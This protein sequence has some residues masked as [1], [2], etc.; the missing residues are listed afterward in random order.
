M[1]RCLKNSIRIVA[2]VAVAILVMGTVGCSTAKRTADEGEVAVK[3][4]K[5][6]GIIISI[7]AVFGEVD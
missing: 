1:Y 4:F 6:D 5:R 3:Q 2:T 7:A